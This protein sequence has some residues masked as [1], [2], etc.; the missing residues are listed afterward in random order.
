MPIWIL[1]LS[2]Y[3]RQKHKITSKITKYISNKIQK[4]F[5]S[6]QKCTSI[7]ILNESSVLQAWKQSTLLSG[8]QSLTEL[9]VICVIGGGRGK[10]DSP[11]TW[12]QSDLLEPVTRGW[13]ICIKLGNYEKS[14]SWRLRKVKIMT[15]AAHSSIMNTFCYCKVSPQYTLAWFISTQSTIL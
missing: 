2:K 7:K 12:P 14:K 3:Q 6:I 13:N 15:S 4:I 5:D 10:T 8:T 11:A 1:R 9:R